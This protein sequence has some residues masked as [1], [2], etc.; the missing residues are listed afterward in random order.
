MSL[1]VIERVII[2]IEEG[3]HACVWLVLLVIRIGT[4]KLQWGLVQ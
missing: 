3:L 1:R 2:N 4:V